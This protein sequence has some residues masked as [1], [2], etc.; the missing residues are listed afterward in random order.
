[1][2]CGGVWRETERGEIET[3]TCHLYPAL[4][5]SPAHGHHRC[6][7]EHRGG[8]FT[9]SLATQTALGFVAKILVCYEVDHAVCN[10]IIEMAT[11]LNSTNT[12]SLIASAAHAEI[13]VSWK[14]EG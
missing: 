9:G 4:L 14:L 10:A 1:M 2:E 7:A 13:P 8:G 6:R 5:S 11:C 3:N 12:I